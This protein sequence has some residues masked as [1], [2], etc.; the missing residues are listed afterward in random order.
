[1][2]NWL[3]RKLKPI[4]STVHVKECGQKLD[5][6]IANV[7]TRY[8]VQRNGSRLTVWITLSGYEGDVYVYVD[9][10][11]CKH[12]V[13]QFGNL[14]T[15]CQPLYK[16]Y[17]GELIINQKVIDINKLKAVNGQYQIY[18]IVGN[19]TKTITL[20]ISDDPSLL[21]QAYDQQRQQLAERLVDPN[22]K[23]DD[24]N[25]IKSYRP[26]LGMYT[27]YADNYYRMPCKGLVDYILKLCEV[28]KRTYSYE[29]HDCDDFSF[30]LQG[31]LNSPELSEGAFFII[32]TGSHALNLVALA[33]GTIKYIEPQSGKLIDRNDGVFAIG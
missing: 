5:Y 22:L 6:K 13:N 27:K 21:E 19:H 33:D 23:L 1:M 10:L 11:N 7:W 18:L 26:Q 25:S 20:N 29:D 15:D 14:T 4:T 30:A 2:I 3:R 16:K 32:W 9:Y 28:S 24:T 8:P 17:K 31:Y 12:Y